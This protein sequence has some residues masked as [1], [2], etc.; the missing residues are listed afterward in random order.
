MDLDDRLREWAFYFRDR[1]KLERCKS[2]EH[3]FQATSDDAE[4]EG[5]G[6]PSPPESRSNR[7]YSIRRALQT[8]DVIQQL[9]KKYKWVV[10]YGY[11]YPG[12][13]RFVVLRALKRFTGARFTWNAYLDAL[14]IGR[15]RVYAMLARS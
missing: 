8:H 12:L 4:K 6:E 10:T 3:R 11:A 7:L 13:P 2:I 15:M 1:K 9:D 14:G 5:W